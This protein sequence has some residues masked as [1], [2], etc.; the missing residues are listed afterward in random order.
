MKK[1]IG[2]FFFTIALVNCSADSDLVDILA[3]STVINLTFP[4][5]LSECTEGTWVSDTESELTFLWEKIDIVETYKMTLT[6]LNNSETQE[7]ESTEAQLKVTL[8]RGTPYSW[9]I[10][11]ASNP[12]KIRSETWVF[13]NEG[14]GLETFAPTPAIALSPVSGASIS[15]TS[16]VVNLR[17]KAEDFDN[18]I[19]GYDIYFGENNDPGIFETDLENPQ[20]NDIPVTS[21]KNILLENSN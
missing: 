15:A 1:K 12:N 20:F 16:T 13:F 4:K 17:W 6:D 19:I 5:N 21:R 10:S 14:P 18:D 2:L 11:S 7:L 3:P 9:N 8:K